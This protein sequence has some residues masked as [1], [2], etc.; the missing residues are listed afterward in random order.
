MQY[1]PVH[2]GICVLQTSCVDLLDAVVGEAGLYD[3]GNRCTRCC[4]EEEDTLTCN[5]RV[6]I[7]QR[8]TVYKHVTSVPNSIQIYH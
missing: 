4:H 7:T 8:P 5:A 6:T 1:A 2:E 3:P